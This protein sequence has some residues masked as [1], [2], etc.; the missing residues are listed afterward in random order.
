MNVKQLFAGR[1]KQKVPSWKKQEK[2]KFPLVAGLIVGIAAV[3]TIA[4]MKA[5]DKQTSRNLTLLCSSQ[6][7]LV[8][9]EKTDG[10]ISFETTTSRTTVDGM[11]KEDILAARFGVAEL[12]I[13]AMPPDGYRSGTL[14]FDRQAGTL[15]NGRFTVTD[16]NMLVQ[17]VNM[18]SVFAQSP[19]CLDNVN[20][21]MTDAQE[22]AA[23]E[24]AR[25]PNK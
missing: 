13:S 17:S 25:A 20:A 24:M 16:S 11:I 22:V 8:Q 7:G 4:A 10:K 2:S 9:V 5:G 18:E 6:G 19:T 12:S 15:Q 1:G 3:G 23:F 21:K 14:T